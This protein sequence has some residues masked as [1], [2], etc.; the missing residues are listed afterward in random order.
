[1][2]PGSSRNSRKIAE[3]PAEKNNYQL[4]YMEALVQALHQS[5]HILML[6]ILCQVVSA[7]ISAI[8]NYESNLKN[9]RI[10]ILNVLQNIFK[11]T[12]YKVTLHNRSYY[13]IILLIVDIIQKIIHSNYANIILMKN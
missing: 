6:T 5:F 9:T 8:S 1:M 12:K 10:I 13:D 3:V 7:G 2:H 11:T 4:L